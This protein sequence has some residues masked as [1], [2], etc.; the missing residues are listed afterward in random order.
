MVKEEL[1]KVN[2]KVVEQ[3]IYDGFRLSQKVN[4]PTMTFSNIA[5]PPS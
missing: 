2:D 3:I 1:M 5:L 4:S